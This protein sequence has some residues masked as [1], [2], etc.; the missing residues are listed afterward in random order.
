MSSTRA[1]Q[2]LADGVRLGERRALARAITLL[3]ST[4]GD[5]RPRADA[6][7]NALLPATGRALR[8]GISG[9]P[10][11]GK[12]T[13]IEALGLQLIGRGHRVAVLAVDPSSSRRAAPSGDKDPHGAWVAQEVIHRRARRAARRRRRRPHGGAASLRGAGLTSAHRDCRHRPER[14]HGRRHTDLFVWLQLPNA[15]DGCR[16]QGGV[17][18]VADLTSTRPTRQRRRRA[19]AT[20]AMSGAASPRTAMA[21]RRCCRS[22]PGEGIAGTEVES[23]AS[24][25]RAGLRCASPPAVAGGCGIRLPTISTPTRPCRCRRARRQRGA[26]RATGRARLLLD[27]LALRTAPCMTSSRNSRPRARARQGGEKR[28]AA[29]RRAS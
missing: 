16:D 6:L 25:A 7:L 21:P 1:D 8:L 28:I 19:R 11:V 13:F 22:A 15:G 24:G 27:R 2:S 23:P 26:H 10:G 17:M 18:E 20:L 5:D 9:V 4:R 29:A 14:D 12:S 3:E